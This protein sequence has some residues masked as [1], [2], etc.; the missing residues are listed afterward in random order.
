LFSGIQT[1]R[2]EQD[3][4]IFEGVYWSIDYRNGKIEY[5]PPADDMRVVKPGVIGD[6]P[7]VS[8]F[9]KE[10][11]FQG[12]D[13][14]VK[15]LTSLAS[16][17][18]VT[19]YPSREESMAD[20]MVSINIDDFPVI[21][22]AKMCRLDRIVERRIAKMNL[23]F[24]AGKQVAVRKNEF[25]DAFCQDMRECGVAFLDSCYE[26]EHIKD[27]PLAILPAMVD[28]RVPNQRVAIM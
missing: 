4:N 2:E 1:W 15:N 5:R 22:F 9:F 8:I 11:A 14:I 12:V 23:A 21:A 27:C 28:V 26:N 7:L 13:W 6:M 18:V 17:A 24:F 16:P 20:I 25:Y 10:E 3:M 19:I